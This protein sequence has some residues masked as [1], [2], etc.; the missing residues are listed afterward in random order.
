[1]IKATGVLR[2]GSPTSATQIIDVV[3]K[4][5]VKTKSLDRIIGGQIAPDIDEVLMVRKPPEPST[6]R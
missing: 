4:D 5:A 6:S 3:G 1:V 2:D